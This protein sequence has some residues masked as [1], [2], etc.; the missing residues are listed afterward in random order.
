MM[1]FVGLNASNID[2]KREILRTQIFWQLTR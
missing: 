1:S 2:I